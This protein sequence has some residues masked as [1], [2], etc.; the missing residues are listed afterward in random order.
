MSQYTP[1]IYI[2]YERN[3]RRGE[4]PLGDR[5]VR[6]EYVDSE[7]EL[8][9]LE[10][11]L[12]DGDLS[13]IDDPDLLEDG[14]T[15]IRVRFGY[16]GNLSK[17]KVFVLQRI[18]P[19]FGKQITVRLTAYD[20]GVELAGFAVSQIWER[21]DG[22]AYTESEIAEEIAALYGLRA[23]VEPTVTRKLRWEQSGVSDMEFLLQLAEHAVAADPRKQGPY[24]VYVDETTLYFKPMPLDTEPQA[25]FTYYMGDGGENRLIEFNPRS[26]VPQ[27]RGA[28]TQISRVGVDPRTGE[29]VEVVIDG[30][31]D[32]ERNVLGY[33]TL[34]INART[35][36]RNVGIVEDAVEAR[37]GA[38]LSSI[39]ARAEFRDAEEEM[40]E[41]SALVVGDP[42][43]VAKRTVGIMNV[44]RKYSGL[45]YVKEARHVI[46]L[47]G[48]T[49]ELQMVRNATL[50]AEEPS[51]GRE[52]TNMNPGDLEEKRQALQ[53]NARTGDM[54]VID[55]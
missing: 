43:L 7:E 35:G 26:N 41:A 16:P 28:A 23:E 15:R 40:Y 31:E 25:V 55:L 51:H 32:Q 45:W 10:L 3:G 27:L 21:E 22:E 14:E 20:L 46:D 1:I 34:F 37:D 39:Y 49:T 24:T 11:V 50:G 9:K 12:E 2:E 8:S 29:F 53:V 6:F 17:E 48:Y 30:Q 36:E 44:G 52:N 33:T 38:D 4:I 54:E 18:A 47:R 5:L 19:T 42:Q 13:I